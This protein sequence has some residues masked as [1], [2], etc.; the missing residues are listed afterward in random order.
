[1]FNARNAPGK[2]V[3]AGDS[4]NVGGGG[5]SPAAEGQWGF[6]SGAPDARDEQ[7]VFF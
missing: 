5:G 7:T 4:N 6:W 1:V 3:T 2:V